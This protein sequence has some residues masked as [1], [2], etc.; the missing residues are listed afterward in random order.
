M[1]A[2]DPPSNVTG[3]IDQPY[4]RNIPCSGKHLRKIIKLTNPFTSVVHINEPCPANEYNSLVRRHLLHTEGHRCNVHEVFNCLRNDYPPQPLLSIDCEDVI[5][6][7]PPS[8]RKKYRAALDRLRR[9]GLSQKHFKI[10]M[11][12]KHERMS[13]PSDDVTEI[14]LKPP[15]AIQARTCEYNLVAQKYFIPYA[16]RFKQMRFD[17]LRTPFAKGLDPHAIAQ[18]L[19]DDWL[20]CDD[21]VALLMDAKR[22]DSCLNSNWLREEHK[23]YNDHFNSRELF[24][25]LQAQFKNRCRTASGI[26][27]KVPGTRM[28]GDPDT[29]DGNSTCNLALLCHLFRSFKKFITVMGDDSVV[30]F[31]R[32]DI[33][34]ILHRLGQRVYPWD[35]EYSIVGEFEHI[36]FCQCHPVETINGYIMVRTPMRALTRGLA[37]ISQ[38]VVRMPRLYYNW[39]RAVGDCEYSVNP[40][41]PVMTS[42]A[43]YFQ[44]FSDKPMKE[45]HDRT[46]FKML[47]G[48][49]DHRI[50]MRARLSFQ[51][52]FGISLRTQQRVEKW[53]NSNRGYRVRRVRVVSHPISGPANILLCP[54]D[55]VIENN[56]VDAYQCV[57]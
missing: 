15:R 27:Y 54:E 57:A 2:E 37:C 52:A 42:M 16:K 45:P 7:K 25:L 20:Q 40:G 10:K 34:Y 4:S 8:Q 41:V 31:E 9:N 46:R 38:T 50:T 44:S 23:Y 33:P 13:Y 17:D 49:Y 6:H 19:Y 51:T 43:R 11:F 22:W 48:N 32:R 29:S 3:L 36:E 28:S 56:L 18:Q 47:H 21:P 26:R 24:D 30:I 55:D 39:L 5:K 35:I 53:F 1:L 14:F 12:V